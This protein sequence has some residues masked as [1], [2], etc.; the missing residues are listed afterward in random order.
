M[1][2][3]IYRGILPLIVVLSLGML[4]G[5]AGAEPTPTAT[6]RVAEPT[7]TPTPAKWEPAK[8]VAF[9]IQTPPGGGSDI[10]ARTWGSAAEK[11]GWTPQPMVPL[12]KPGA[13][14]AIAL[15]YLFENFGDAHFLTPTLNSVITTPMVQAISVRYP[16]EDLTPIA[17][18]AMDP[19]VLWSANF[20]TWDDFVAAAEK[21]VVTAGGT[22]PRQEDTIQFAVLQKALQEVVGIEGAEI[23]YIPYPGGGDVAKAMAGGEIDLSVNQ[24]SEALPF[25]PERVNALAA[26]IQERLKVLP[27]VPTHYELMGLSPGESKW[28]DLLSLET[29]L[30]QHRGVIAPPGLSDAQIEG[31][32]EIFRKVSQSKEWLDVV[33]RFAMV[34][35]FKGH[36]EY[37]E[38]LRNYEKRHIEIMRDVLGWEFRDDFTPPTF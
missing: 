20:E 10:Y 9:V 14:G 27:D 2:L 19:F 18:M 38:F 23:K 8:P 7:A 33:D 35:E 17:L 21:G 1:K 25:Y 5:C 16:S 34:P 13:A 37:V 26:F 12:N 15:N 32:E 11:N 3:P 28:G 30:H 29:G 31:F 22:G 36:D 6:P 4:A 24:P